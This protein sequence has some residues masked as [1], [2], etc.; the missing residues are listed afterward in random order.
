[1]SVPF[2]LL[3]VWSPFLVQES[4]LND[5]ERIQQQAVKGLGHSYFYQ[6]EGAKRANCWS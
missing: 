6:Q 5:L 3:T 4:L 1:M 2:N